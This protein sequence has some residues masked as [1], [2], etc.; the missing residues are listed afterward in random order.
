MDFG[1]EIAHEAVSLYTIVARTRMHT[2]DANVWDLSIVQGMAIFCRR[3][4]NPN[5]NPK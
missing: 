5:P 3:V 2:Y 1:C 4:P